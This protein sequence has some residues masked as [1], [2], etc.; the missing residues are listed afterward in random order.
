MSG[1]APG[2]TILE[3]GED[4]DAS[5]SNFVEEQE[6]KRQKEIDDKKQKVTSVKK[7]NEF[8]RR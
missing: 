6:R 7:K 5:V 3:D 1:I 4:A 8:T 2:G